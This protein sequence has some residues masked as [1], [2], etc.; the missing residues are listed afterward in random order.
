[1]E[2][3]GKE[4]DVLI[5]SVDGGCPGV[6]SVKSGVIGATSQQYPLLMASKGIEA[7][8]A[9][10]KDGTKPAAS[11]GLTFFNTGV[12]LVTDSPADGVPSIDS[13]KG[14]ELCWG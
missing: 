9:F 7:I 8:A 10:A 11:D 2:K 1:L 12:N 3:A 14:T 6:A 13:T 4:K 5:V